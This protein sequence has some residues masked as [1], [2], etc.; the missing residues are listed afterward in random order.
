MERLSLAAMELLLEVA[1]AP[2]GRVTYGMLTRGSAQTGRELLDGGWLAQS[3]N[4]DSV[5]CEACHDDHAAEVEF[6]RD[7][8][9]RHYC[10]HEAWVTVPADRL[11]RYRVVLGPR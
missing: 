6:D 2:G 3:E 7:Q 10:P 5:I 4:L 1:E 9:F 11:R 8:G